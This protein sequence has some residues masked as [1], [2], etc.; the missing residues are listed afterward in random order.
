MKRIGFIGLGSIGAPMARCIVRAGY[1]TTACDKRPQ[2]LGASKEMGA[3][4][5]E[6]VYDCADRD[7]VIV[8]VADDA[9]VWEFV[10]G[11]NGLLPA[12]DQNRPLMLAVMR[13]VLPETI[14]KLAPKCAE[15]LCVWWMPR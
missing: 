9:Q 11:S 15:K 12:V 3:I 2:A 14:Q 4:V 7:V 10:L 8:M 5:T 1:Q 6:K 13:T